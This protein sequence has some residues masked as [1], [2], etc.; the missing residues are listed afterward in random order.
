MSIAARVPLMT[1]PELTRLYENCV[2]LSQGA[3][4]KQRD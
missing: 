4:G 1:L 3:L 2:R